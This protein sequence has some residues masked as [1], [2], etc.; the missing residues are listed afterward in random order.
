MIHVGLDEFEG[1]VLDHAHS[2]WIEHSLEL[3]HLVALDALATLGG[4]QSSL[5][6]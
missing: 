6:N 1:V 2:L 4:F 5:K 3:L